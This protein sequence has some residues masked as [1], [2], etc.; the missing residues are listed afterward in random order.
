M[1][2]YSIPGQKIK[3]S[4]IRYGVEH[5]RDASFKRLV[6]GIVRSQFFIKSKLYWQEAT[7]NHIIL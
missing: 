2:P 3:T 5:V 4:K 6:A 1:R 7:A